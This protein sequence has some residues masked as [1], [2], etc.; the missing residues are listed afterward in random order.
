[1]GLY[2]VACG[3][4][5]AA[6]VAKALRPGDTA[7]A[8]AG[9]LP[10]RVEPMRATVRFGSVAEAVLG[11]VALVFPR[12]GSAWLVA[13]SYATFAIVISIARSKGGAISSCG[14]F[15]TP[16]TPA[17]GLHVVVNAG[18]AISAAA[19]AVAAPSGT[20]V[21]ILSHEPWHGLPLVAVS[22]LCAWLTY[23]AISVLAGL[24][25]ARRMT[26]ISHRSP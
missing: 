24:Q 14:C 22:A 17:T 21:S 20:I 2:L 13:L 12:T 7:R 6:G 19:V 8:L 18:L 4:L 23:L 1:M 16:D 5:I 25:A 11:L 10:I 26:A 9:V 3:L 15:G